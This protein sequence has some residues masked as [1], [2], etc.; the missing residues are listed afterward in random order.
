MK[1][2]LIALLAVALFAA[3]HG[4]VTPEQQH[5]EKAKPGER[6]TTLG[7]ALDKAETVPCGEYL[8]Q[9]SQAAQMYYQNN[10]KYPPDLQALAKEA[11]LQSILAD[12]KFTYDPATGKVGLVR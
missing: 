11:Q 7:K 3:L 2:P 9:L 6:T 8:S 12:C 10:E 5:M 1:T 4:C